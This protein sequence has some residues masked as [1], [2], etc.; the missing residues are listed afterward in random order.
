MGIEGGPRLFSWSISIFDIV[1]K[2]MLKHNYEKT[3][4]VDFGGLCSYS[5]PCSPFIS[6]GQLLW[7]LVLHH[8]EK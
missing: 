2:I 4:N 3:V 8:F 6:I 1:T 5:E 7:Q